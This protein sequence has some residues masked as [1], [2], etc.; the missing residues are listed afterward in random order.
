MADNNQN[1]V[2][3]EAG[4]AS[5]HAE[6]ALFTPLSAPILRLVDLIQVAKFFKY[7]ERYELKVES[8]QA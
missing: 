6:G 3:H 4:A 7:L 1:P 5:K 2:L 8:K